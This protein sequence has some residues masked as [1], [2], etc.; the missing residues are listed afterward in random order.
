MHSSCWRVLCAALLA[1]RLQCALYAGK[2]V[3]RDDAQIPYLTKL[4]AAQRKY[5]ERA[6]AAE[7]CAPW[8]RVVQAVQRCGGTCTCVPPT[9]VRITHHYTTRNPPGCVAAFAVA[10]RNARDART[11]AAVAGLERFELALGRRMGAH[12]NLAFAT[13]VPLAK[14]RAPDPLTPIV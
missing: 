5:F 14:L 7:L 6:V 1:V 4:S 13:V 11:I 10:V 8:V 2:L 12:L 3:M 9:W